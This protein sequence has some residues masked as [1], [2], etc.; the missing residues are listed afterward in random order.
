MGKDQPLALS[1]RSFSGT[2]GGSPSCP[3]MNPAGNRELNDV[4]SSLFSQGSSLDVQK[5]FLPA[6]CNPSPEA[7][8]NNSVSL[9]APTM[10][11]ALMRRERHS[12][13]QD[14]VPTLKE[15]TFSCRKANIIQ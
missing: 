10:C 6:E 8:F 13:E 2:P 3:C 1:P 7:S 15:L 14:K 5:S 11:P 9:W 12:I 4:C